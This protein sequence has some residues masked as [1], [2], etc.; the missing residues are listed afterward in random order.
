[1]KVKPEEFRLYQ[2]CKMW[3][4]NLKWEGI[5]VY[6]CSKKSGKLKGNENLLDFT[7]LQKI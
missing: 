5:R 6:R 7:D 4:T 2:C 3:K 1:M